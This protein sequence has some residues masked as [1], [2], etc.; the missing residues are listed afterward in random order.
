M[1]LYIANELINTG[2]ARY[3]NTNLLRTDFRIEWLS[4]KK[5]IK[6]IFKQK[7]KSKDFIIIYSHEYELKK[8]KNKHLVLKCASV[9]K[10]EIKLNNLKP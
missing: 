10:N 5:K 3:K 4:K 8:N 1:P 9:I 6:N 7:L 2:Y